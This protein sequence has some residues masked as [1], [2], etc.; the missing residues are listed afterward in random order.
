[1]WVFVAPKTSRVQNYVIFWLTLLVLSELPRTFH[2]HYISCTYEGRKFAFTSN[3][4]YICLDVCAFAFINTWQILFCTF[5]VFWI[6]FLWL[7]LL[8]NSFTVSCG[9]LYAACI[10]S[11]RQNLCLA[12][13]LLPPVLF[14][15]RSSSSV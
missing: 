2:K 14:L 12:P 11:D 7:F 13:F 3:C 10:T 4:L 8:K 1:M 15:L 9:W 5:R 6:I